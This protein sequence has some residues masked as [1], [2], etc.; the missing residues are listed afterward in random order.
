MKGRGDKEGKAEDWNRWTRE[1]L[2]LENFFFY[3]LARLIIVIPQPILQH[4][5]T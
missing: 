1:E 5:P 2:L 4:Q 3:L